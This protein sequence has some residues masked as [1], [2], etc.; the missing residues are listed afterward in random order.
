MGVSCFCVC[1]L[2]RDLLYVVVSVGV[3]FVLVFDFGVIARVCCHRSL[4]VFFQ[5]QGLFLVMSVVVDSAFFLHVD[6]EGGLCHISV[7]HFCWQ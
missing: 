1:V 4:L 5:R 6:K 7:Y 3:S 2:L